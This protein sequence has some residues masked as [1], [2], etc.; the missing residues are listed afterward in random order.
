MTSWFESMRGRPTKH[1]FP[2]VVERNTHGAQNATVFTAMRVRLS[3]SGPIFMPHKDIDTKRRYQREWKQRRRLAWLAAHGPCVEC[4][5]SNKL[6][7]DHKESATKIDHNVWSWAKVKR[8]AELSKCQ[9]LCYN[10]HLAKTKL[11]YQ[12]W[13]QHNAS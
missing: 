9:V 13:L 4:G 7:V 3:P 8:E 1:N 5:S 2:E 11:A 12:M 6:E 10:C